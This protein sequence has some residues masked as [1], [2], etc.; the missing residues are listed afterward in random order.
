MKMKNKIFIIAFTTLFLFSSCGL[1]IKSYIRKDTENVPPDLGKEKTTMLVLQ[2]R[3]SY[4]KKIEKILKDN[5]S[6]D[7][8]FVTREELDTKYSDTLK[9]RYLLDD[10]ILISGGP[11]NV[12]T[13]TTNTQTGYKYS[14]K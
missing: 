7:Y 5:Y 11:V 12:T 10:D 2:E 1:I 4:T 3:K 14:K 8:V 13:R 9:Y 6:G